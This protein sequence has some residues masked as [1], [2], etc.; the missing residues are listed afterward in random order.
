MADTS[1]LPGS[2]KRS[3]VLAQ[4]DKYEPKRE[5]SPTFTAWAIAFVGFMLLGMGVWA[6]ADVALKYIR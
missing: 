3:E 5:P 4:A 1:P 6:I 2:L